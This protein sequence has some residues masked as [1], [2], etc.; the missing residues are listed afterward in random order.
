[1]FYA[2]I[3][4]FGCSLDNGFKIYI[5]YI[6]QR[7]IKEMLK[8]PAFYSFETKIEIRLLPLDLKRI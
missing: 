6:L 1:M 5:S 3:I 7:N 2:I 8:I 4:N